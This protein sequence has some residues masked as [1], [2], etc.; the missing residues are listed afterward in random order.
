MSLVEKVERAKSDYDEVYE[1]GKQ[2]EYDAFWDSYQNDGSRRDYQ[3]AFCKW[4]D[5]CYKPKY[6]I[7]ITSSKYTQLFYDSKITDTLVDIDVSHSSNT[8]A[9]YLAFGFMTSLVTIRKLI[10]HEG[11]GYNGTFSACGNLE[12][13]TIEGTIG[14]NGFNVSACT[15]LSHDSLMSIINH[16]KDGV[17]GLT[18]TLGSTNLAKL[19]DA[20]KAIA[21]QKGWTLA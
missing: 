9:M 16:L 4:T 11:L 10:V 6:P 3:F 13:L 7:V 8:S 18:V 1:A 15:E 5:A 17:S 19:T 21:T 20:E 12:N 14:Q 2:A